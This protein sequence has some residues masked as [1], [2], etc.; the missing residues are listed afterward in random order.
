MDSVGD[1]EVFAIPGDFCAEQEVAWFGSIG[2]QSAFLEMHAIEDKRERWFRWSDEQGSPFR[3][4]GLEMAGLCGCEDPALQPVFQSVRAGR[5]DRIAAEVDDPVPIREGPRVPPLSDL[6]V[7]NDRG[8]A[9]D[10]EM[11]R[12]RGVG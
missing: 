11:T 4:A 9:M 6:V 10:A 5:T 7:W 2:G 3:T 1:G 12:G 8:S